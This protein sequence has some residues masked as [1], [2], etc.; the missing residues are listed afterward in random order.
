MRPPVLPI[1]LALCVF[2]AGC[3]TDEAAERGAAEGRLAARLRIEH[4]GEDTLTFTSPDAVAGDRQ[5][6][7]PIRRALRQPLESWTLSWRLAL[8]ALRLDQFARGATLN[9]AAAAAVPYDGSLDGAELRLQHL[10]VPSP[11]VWL[12]VD[13]FLDLELETSDE[14]GV[15]ALRI[16][17]PG[18]A[19]VDLQAR[20][21]R[22]VLDLPQGSCVDGAHWLDERRVVVLVDEPAPGGRRPVLYLVHVAAENAVRYFGPAAPAADARA[23]RTDLDRRFRAARPDLE[24]AAR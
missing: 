9:F 7:E 10:V 11:A 24:V 2:A 13:P 14:G 19:V 18:I 23:A 22:R 16:D 1:L 12:L 20:T 4:S 5:L 8:P 15:R 21:E 6:P 3:S 17:E